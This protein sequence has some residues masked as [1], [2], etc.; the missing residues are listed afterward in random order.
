MRAKNGEARVPRTS[1][2]EVQ[3]S[4]GGASMVPMLDPVCAVDGLVN[5]FRPLNGLDK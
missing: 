3:T 1:L 5:G 2:T 4:P